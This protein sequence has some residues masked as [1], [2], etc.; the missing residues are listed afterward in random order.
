MLACC[1]EPV[2]DDVLEGGLVLAPEA[3]LT[4]VVVV[5]ADPL[6]P[7]LLA[8]VV[9][10]AELLETAVVG[11]VVVEISLCEFPPPTVVVVDLGE[12]VVVVE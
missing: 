8:G 5:E 3:T 12:V 1:A 9:V 10:V 7:A 11:V 2:G 4:E 6:D